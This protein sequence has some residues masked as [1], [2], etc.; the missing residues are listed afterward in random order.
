MSIDNSPWLNHS[1][2]VSETPGIEISREFFDRIF[3]EKKAGI[4]QY[5]AEHD[6]E[7][8]VVGM[9]GDVDSAVTAVMLSKMGF[10]VVG[11]NI[12]INGSSDDQLLKC[13]LASIKKSAPN[14]QMHRLDARR[15][16]QTLLEDNLGIL[17]TESVRF[18]T[19]IYHQIVIGL[20]D[21]AARAFPASA[22][23]STLNTTELYAG[24][25]LK[26]ELSH[27]DLF[28]FLDLFK[29]QIRMFGE[30]LGLRRLI[31]GRKPSPQ[32]VPKW[33][34]VDLMNR[35]T[36]F[37]QVWEDIHVV[38]DDDNIMLPHFL[39]QA[40]DPLYSALE[41]GGTFESLLA[42]DF[43]QRDVLLAQRLRQYFHYK[44]DPMVTLANSGVIC[45]GKFHQSYE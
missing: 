36:R 17:S 38:Q 45:I 37:N 20:L 14:I 11:I 8:L 30:F 12:A 15:S 5:M 25:F 16:L 2:F 31:M 13:R 43:S 32:V 33:L 40:L 23:V 1:A 27:G 18:R 26:E 35:P 3:E 39:Y 34:M 28:P 42:S 21:T 9:S 29:T 19:T 24:A 10:P 41:A 7:V 6:R 22:R 44:I 4:T